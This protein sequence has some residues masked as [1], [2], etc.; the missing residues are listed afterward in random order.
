MMNNPQVM[1]I[2]H[3]NILMGLDFG[4]D[5]LPSGLKLQS[6]APDSFISLIFDIS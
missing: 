6:T 1:M 3:H 4:D 2:P 5:D